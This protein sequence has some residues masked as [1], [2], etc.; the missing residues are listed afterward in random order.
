VFFTFFHVSPIWGHSG[1]HITL[2]K[3]KQWFM[4]MGMSSH[5]ATHVKAHKICGLSKPAHEQHYV[6]L[7]LDLASHSLRKCLQIL[8]ENFLCQNLVIHMS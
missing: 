6:M 7:S 5:I 1:I 4:R 2:Y 8:S 3:I